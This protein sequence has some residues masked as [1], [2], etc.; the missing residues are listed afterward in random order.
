ML[1]QILESYLSVRRACG[2]GFKTQEPFLRS[3]VSYSYSKGKNYIRS[4]VAIEWAGLAP[5][6]YQRASRLGYVIQLARYARLEDQSHELPP[7]VFGSDNR[8]R[9]TPYIFS[10]NNIQRLVQAAS[11]LGCHSFRRK[12]YSTLFALLACTGLRTSESIRLR[13]DDITPDGLVVRC[14]LSRFYT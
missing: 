12:T 13:F 2:F 5:S 3:F 4:E 11:E 1:A 10:Q 9:A 14:R 6:V 7:A 8:P